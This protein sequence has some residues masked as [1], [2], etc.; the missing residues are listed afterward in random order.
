MRIFKVPSGI[1]GASESGTNV[2][3]V[4]EIV[5]R[6][7]IAAVEIEDHGMR[8]FGARN[9]KIAKLTGALAIGDAG[10]GRRCG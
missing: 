6:S 8:T 3:G 10:V 5:S 1:T 9:S 7:P 2:A 4:C